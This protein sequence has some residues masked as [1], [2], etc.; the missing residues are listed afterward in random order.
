M[1]ILDWPGPTEYRC[2]GAV[3][4]FHF[5]VP[6]SSRDHTM[7][8]GTLPNSVDPPSDSWLIIRIHEQPDGVLK[9]TNHG[10]HDLCLVV[11]I[12]LKE[13]FCEDSNA[14]A[15]SLRYSVSS[16]S[17][18][19]SFIVVSAS[20]KAY[21]RPLMPNR[22][23]STSLL[24]GSPNQNPRTNK[25]RGLRGIPWLASPVPFPLRRAVPNHQ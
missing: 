16:S 21:S 11:A 23:S 7:F 15:S 9:V 25:M 19:V 5:L 18:I 2:D 1:T 20:I 22:N 17:M 24:G 10:T 4:E 12:Q 3:E 14:S 13:A 6:L 8:N